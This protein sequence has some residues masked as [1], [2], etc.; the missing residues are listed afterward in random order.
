MNKFE[1][2][3]EKLKD[4]CLKTQTWFE[5]IIEDMT[6]SEWDEMFGEGA[7]EADFGESNE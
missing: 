5:K 3:K 4:A 1:L 2:D 7:W 6:P